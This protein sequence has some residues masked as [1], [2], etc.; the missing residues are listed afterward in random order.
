ME[1]VGRSIAEIRR[2]NEKKIIESVRVRMEKEKSRQISIKEGVA[3][4]FMTGFGDSYI[5]PFALHL[6]ANNVH[7]GLLTSLT[8]LFAPFTQILGSKLMERFK[9]KKIVA[10]FVFLQ[11]LIWPLFIFL[12]YLFWKGTIV[13]SLPLLIIAV[14]ILYAILGSIAGP[15]WFSWI[16]DLVPAEIRGKYFSKRNVICGIAGL[17]TMLAGGLLLD[18]FKTRGFI[19]LG[20][21]VIFVIAMIGRLVSAYYFTKQFEPKLKLEDG[22]YFSL[23]SFIKKAPFNN[24]GRFTIFVACVHSAAA[25]AG[26]F[27]AVYMLNDL[28]FSYTTYTLVNLSASIFSLLSMPIFGRFADR[29]GNRKLLKFGWLLVPIMPFLWLISPNPYYIAFVPQ[30]IGGIGWAAFNLASGNFIYDSVSPERRGICVAYYNVFAGV[31]IFIGATL[32]GFLAQYVHFS[33]IKTFFF[34]FVVSG[35]LRAVAGFIL[36]PK[37]KEVR[38]VKKEGTLKAFMEVMPSIK[39]LHSMDGIVYHTIGVFKRGMFRW[40]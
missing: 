10:L 5:T 33:F 32:G 13:S 21:S 39:H 4:S 22:Y 16:G 27:F 30:L 31:G 23:W 19:L 38:K 28:N 12:G 17:I 34:I 26:P 25:I 2:D 9:R 8:N 35:V 14:Y 11:V 37:I 40:R 1:K 36:L 29:F 24:F 20:F 7:I 3:S 18:L 6:N 15:A